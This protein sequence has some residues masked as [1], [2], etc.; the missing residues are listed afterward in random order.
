MSKQPDHDEHPDLSPEIGEDAAWRMLAQPMREESDA[1][2]AASREAGLTAQ[3][4]LE[5]LLGRLEAE[6]APA[7]STAPA[8]TGAGAPWWMVRTQA[9]AIVALAASLAVV[10][11][12]LPVQGSGPG[13]ESPFKVY[14]DGEGALGTAQLTVVF[15]PELSLGEM[16]TLLESVNGQISAGRSRV[17]T[18]DVS[19]RNPEDD[20]VSAA[21]QRLRGDAHVLMAE[22][23]DGKGP[24]DADDE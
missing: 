21:L 9:A 7:A 2:V 13:T 18:F 12:W 23:V 24:A 1:Q 22:R 3:A 8:A 6:D 20:A 14:E 19:L 4:G 11:L 10:A 17:G 5:K 16:Q 15:A